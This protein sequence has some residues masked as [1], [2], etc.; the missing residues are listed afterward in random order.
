[1]SKIHCV[2]AYQVQASVPPLAETQGFNGHPPLEVNAT[3]PQ[4]QR[5]GLVFRVRFNGHPPLGVNATMD[6]YS[7]S[8]WFHLFQCAPTLGGECYPTNS[9]SSPS[10]MRSNKP[11]QWAPT[12]GGE[13][14][15]VDTTTTFTIGR[16]SFNGHPPLGVNATP[17]RNGVRAG[18][19][20]GFQWAPT[21]GGECYFRLTAERGCARHSWVSMGTHPW[22]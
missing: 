16:G 14:Y 20:S 17:R 21:L 22:G 19:I 9:S 3:V 18:L 8:V 6:D 5:L 11:F 7:V 1:M 4:L 15:S 12:L 13:C 2:G 10:T